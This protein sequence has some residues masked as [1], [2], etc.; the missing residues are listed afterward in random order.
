MGLPGM[1]G[2][3]GMRGPPGPKGDRATDGIIVST[4]DYPVRM[5]HSYT[6]MSFIQ[7]ASALGYL[8]DYEADRG[9]L[10]PVAGPPGPPGMNKNSVSP[11]LISF[12]L[13]L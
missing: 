10:E 1:M 9:S 2:P 7:H 12:E 3:P 8:K 5:I 6:M 11:F 4:N 13:L